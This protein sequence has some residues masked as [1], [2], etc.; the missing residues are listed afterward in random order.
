[1]EVKAAEKKANVS[2]CYLFQNCAIKYSND[3]PEI[4]L[5]F[6][7]CMMGAIFPNNAAPMVR[8]NF[9]VCF[10]KNFLYFIT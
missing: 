1:M 6:I 7:N 2:F 8:V 4:Y 3:D 5:P 10:Q 9:E